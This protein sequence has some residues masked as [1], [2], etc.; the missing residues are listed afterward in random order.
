MKEAVTPGTIIVR[1]Q[2]RRLYYVTGAGQ[3]ISYPVGVG[4]VGKQWSGTSYIS[5][6]YT[7]PAWS[8]PAEVRRDKPHLPQV[9][10]GGSP[11]NP[12]G[13]AAMTLSGGEYA[14]HGT[15]QPNSIGHSFPM[16]ASGCTTRTS[17]TCTAGSASARGWLSNSPPTGGPEAGG[18]GGPCG[19]LRLMAAVDCPTT[20]LGGQHRSSGYPLSGCRGRAHAS[21]RAGA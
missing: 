20:S 5:G 12:M 4:R 13:V 2:E 6:K 7:H 14:I 11:G 9:I 1:T 17:E 19:W 21:S 16:A 15:N 18:S 10:P 8:P 3:A